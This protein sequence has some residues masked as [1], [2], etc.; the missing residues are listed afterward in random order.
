[1]FFAKNPEFNDVYN[2]YNRHLYNMFE[3]FKNC[4]MY[5]IKEL[6][7]MPFTGRDDFFMLRKFLEKEEFDDRMLLEQ[8]EL[9]EY[10]LPPLQAKEIKT[11]LTEE[12]GRYNVKQ[13]AAMYKVIRYSYASSCTSFGCQAL[14]I[15]RFFYLIWEASRRMANALLENQ[16]FE[17]L[18]RHYDCET[19]FFYLD[20][21]Y[22]DAEDYAVEFPKEDHIRLRDLL[23]SIK[24]RFML[25]YND[26][27]EI[28]RLYEDIPG[29]NIFAYERLDSIAQRNIPGKMYKELLIANYDMNERMRILPDQL[30][31]FDIYD[32]NEDFDE[33]A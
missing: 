6:G 28:R 14:D 16:D 13:A 5:I 17:K 3:C 31:L 18:I 19:A 29:I 22:F 2:D 24:G 20:P 9:A 1:M 23:I 10:Y 25:S 15:R 27:P 12:A 4:P 33:S 26:T 7:F 8:A 30:T 21:P 32:E 11:I